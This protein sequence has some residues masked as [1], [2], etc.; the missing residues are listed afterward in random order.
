MEID[1]SHTSPN[2][3]SRNGMAITMLVLHATAG[4]LQSSLAWL[5]NPKS[6]VS[7]H[8]LIGTTGQIY[9]LVPD[10]RCAWHAGV[11]AWDGITAVNPRSIGIELENANTG[12]DPYPSAQYAALVTLTRTLLLAHPILAARIVRH[13]DIAVPKGRKSDPA[14]FDW[15]RYL[16]DVTPYAVP[17]PVMRVREPA[18]ANLRTL[19][20][21][22][23]PV[24]AT[25]DYGRQ[26]QVA[27]PVA[28]ES[29]NGGGNNLW[30]RIVGFPHDGYVWSGLLE[31][32]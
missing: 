30:Y 16:A 14:G 18:G 21:R 2:H 29:V 10:T 19:P 28:G 1:R 23:S 15:Q 5:C 7:C 25:L 9:Q 17:N 12:T 11:S 32:V 27:G 26:V 24:V 31:D 6:L 3:S 20:R 4:S 22:S 8:Y 13:L